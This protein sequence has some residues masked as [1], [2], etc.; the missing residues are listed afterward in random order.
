MTKSYPVITQVSPRKVP[1]TTPLDGGFFGQRK[2]RNHG[3]INE[4][5]VKRE[6]SRDLLRRRT[7]FC[8]N[9]FDD[10]LA[11]EADSK[12]EN[13]NTPNKSVNAVKKSNASD[14]PSVSSQA[15]QSCC[16]GLF[17]IVNN[18]SSIFR[19]DSEF[20]RIIA[21]M[22][23]VG[24]SCVLIFLNVSNFIDILYHT[25]PISRSLL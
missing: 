20:Q 11:I 7:E 10:T 8:C 19:F 24:V 13:N 16:V 4:K 15:D 1:K 22:L 9:C 14:E 21:L 2:H 6:E 3:I 18:S 5:Q 25:T 17:H 12:Y 23:P